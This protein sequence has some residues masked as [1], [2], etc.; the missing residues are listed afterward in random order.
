M[1]AQCMAATQTKLQSVISADLIY[2][3]CGIK[4]IEFIIINDIKLIDFIRTC[5]YLHCK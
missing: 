4:K 2:N 5:E 1:L 3:T